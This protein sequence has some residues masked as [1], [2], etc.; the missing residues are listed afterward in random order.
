MTKRPATQIDD[1][2]WVT[3]AWRGQHEQCC[4]CGSR[5][6]VDYR[7]VAD[8]YLPGRPLKF[9]GLLQFRARRLGRKQ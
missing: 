7:V 4:T 2:E 3:V 1:G 6:V 8:E 5:H 9:K